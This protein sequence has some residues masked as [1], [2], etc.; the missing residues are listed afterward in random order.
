MVL[1]IGVIGAGLIGRDHIRRV[2]DDL[3]GARVSAVADV[4]LDRAK[5]VAAGLPAAKPLPTGLDVI[6]DDDVDAVLVTS[7]G[8]THEEYVLAAIAEGKQVFCEKP[9]AT[10]R[11][12][13]ERIIDAEVAAGKRLVMVGYMRR[14][15]PAYRALKAAVTAGEIGAPLM[16]HSVHRN[17]AVP[18]HY[19]SNM[20]INDTCAHDV[21]ITRFLLE[22]EVAAVR[23][24]TPARRNR[25]DPE[26]LTEAMLVLEMANGVLVDVEA[27]INIAYGYDI[28]GEIVGETGT[29]SLGEAT[30]TVLR[31]DGGYRGQVP[32]NWQDRFRSA[33]DAE[34]RAWI[35]AASRGES[36]GPSTWDGYA[37]TVVCETGLAAWRTGDRVEASLRDKPGL[38]GDPVT[39]ASHE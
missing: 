2:T 24:L 11:E 7:W 31:R 37:T 19:S 13:C 29:V 1:N 28:R 30:P 10:T 5:S 15:D 20:I 39:P 21:D 33:Y 3:P 22:S 38:Y 26:H 25:R 12:A 17:P 14:Y 23:V 6:A 35:A 36:T 18:P 16:F 27:S 8:P 34:F 9:L 32:A 4:D